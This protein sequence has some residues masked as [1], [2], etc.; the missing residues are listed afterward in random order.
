M[1]MPRAVNDTAEQVA[2]Y[3]IGAEEMVERGGGETLE[4]HDRPILISNLLIVEAVRRDKIGEYA[5]KEKHQNDD[6]RRG[7]ER[8]CLYQPRE[9]VGKWIASISD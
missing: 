3:A 2:T 7:A 5:D 6:R 8:L 9:E 1:E 4:P